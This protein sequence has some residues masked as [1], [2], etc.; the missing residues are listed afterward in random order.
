MLCNTLFQ[1]KKPRAGRR[2]SAPRARPKTLARRGPAARLSVY[3]RQYRK[4]LSPGIETGKCRMEPKLYA[5]FAPHL[6]YYWTKDGYREPTGSRKKPLAKPSPQNPTLGSGPQ[7]G[8]GRAGGR[9]GPAGA[10][11]PQRWEL[12][13][14]SF[15]RDIS[16]ICLPSLSPS[17]SVHRVMISNV[18]QLDALFLN[19][20]VRMTHFES[21]MTFPRS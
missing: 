15:C 20:L 9:A 17:H 2:A 21:F 14:R 6:K 8:G 12:V 10:P 3:P 1:C 4:L 19:L 7:L 5:I 13:E 16:Y 11:P 18:A